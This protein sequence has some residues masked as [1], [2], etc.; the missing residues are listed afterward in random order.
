MPTRYLSFNPAV[1]DAINLDECITEEHNADTPLPLQNRW[2]VWEQIQREAGA[3]D[4]AADYSQNTRDLASFDTVQ[5]FWQL[6]AHIPQPSELLGHKRMIRQDSNGKSHVVDALMIFKEGIRPM[7]E[8]PMNNDG[9]HYEYK[10]LPNNIRGGQLDEYWNNLVLAIVG[11][12]IYTHN[13][14][15]GIRLVDKLGQGRHPC[16]RIEVWAKKC[17]KAI[18]EKLGKDIE[19]CFATKLVS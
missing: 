5:T 17:D 6:W 18:Q 19:K 11:A 15:N 4:R 13:F 3:L 12:T 8:D 14:I 16:I 7:W 9:G 10:L 2:H 1:T